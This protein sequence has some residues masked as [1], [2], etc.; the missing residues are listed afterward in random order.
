MFKP[1]RAVGMIL[2]YFYYMNTL[3]EYGSMDGITIQEP[4]I[5]IALTQKLS[6]QHI[7]QFWPNHFRW[8][9]GY[10]ADA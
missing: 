9:L 5:Y 10:G 1:G 2:S 4:H 6:M 7:S 3:G 8:A